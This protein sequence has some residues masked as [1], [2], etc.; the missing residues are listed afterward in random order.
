VKVT[1]GSAHVVIAA[2]VISMPTS[3]GAAVIGFEGLI[4]NS[5]VSFTDQGISN[6]YLGHSWSASGGVGD[7]GVADCGA[8]ATCFGDQSLKAHSG[9]SYGW[10]YAGPQSLYVDFAEATDVGGAWFAGQFGNRCPCNSLTMQFFGYDA[11]NVLVAS[12]AVLALADSRWQ[13][14]DAGFSGIYRLELR[15]DRPDSW[16]AIDDLELSPSAVPE[17][18]TLL[19][20]GAATAVLG[21]RRR[22]S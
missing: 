3:A 9:T 4:L 2:M 1:F 16:F 20:L 13:F 11:A 18:A 15:S 6:T 12:S 8:G 7:W 22:R 21:I 17:P 5:E 19:L 10:N 14:L